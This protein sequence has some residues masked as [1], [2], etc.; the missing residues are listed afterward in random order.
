ME[1]DLHCANGTPVL[2]GE[3]LLGP[4]SIQ[5]VD[6]FSEFYCLCELN[7]A[8]LF[9]QVLTLRKSMYTPLIHTPVALSFDMALCH[10][11]QPSQRLPSPSRLSSFIVLHISAAPSS[12][13]QPLS[14][15]SPIFIR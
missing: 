12:L 8:L 5:V 6:V 11:H 4:Y 10:L 3:S 13:S 7:H 14:R 9:R 1:W 15:L 2:P